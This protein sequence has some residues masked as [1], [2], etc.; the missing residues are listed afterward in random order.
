[1]GKLNKSL[2]LKLMI[3]FTA[4]LILT[5]SLILYFSDL[6]IGNKVGFGSSVTTLIE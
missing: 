6:N 3:I 5:I 2:M 4:I 1:M